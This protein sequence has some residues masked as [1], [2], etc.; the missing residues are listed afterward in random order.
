MSLPSISRV[1]A[2]FSSARSKSRC[3][4]SS[5][6]VASLSPVS[7]S[8]TGAVLQQNDVKGRFSFVTTIWAPW[9]QHNRYLT[10]EE[11]CSRGGRCDQNRLASRASSGLLSYLLVF[12]FTQVRTS[13]ISL[14]LPCHEAQPMAP[15]SP[16]A[17]LFLLAS[18]RNHQTGQ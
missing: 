14:S 18:S 17:M 5:A 2:D 16:S 3:I 7:F 11:V 13:H 10:R 6:S 4:C 12:L 9:G 8:N 1:V 15:P